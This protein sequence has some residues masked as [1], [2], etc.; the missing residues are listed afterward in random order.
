MQ[1]PYRTLLPKSPFFKGGF[2]QK[3]RQVAPLV[4][5]G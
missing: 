3:F 5:G 1:I 2:S 4:K